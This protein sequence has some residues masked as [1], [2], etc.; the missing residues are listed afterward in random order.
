MR[1]EGHEVGCRAQRRRG[2]RC[3]GVGEGG[4]G[5]EGVVEGRMGKYLTTGG[6]SLPMYLF[7][8]EVGISYLLK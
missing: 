5:G 2:M 4:C 3:Q 8:W 6:E 1:W 7:H